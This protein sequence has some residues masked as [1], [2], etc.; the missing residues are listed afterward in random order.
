MIKPPTVN[1]P[2]RQLLTFLNH[3]LSI[4]NWINRELAQPPTVN[5]LNH[6]LFN[7]QRPSWLN[8][9]LA[10][11]SIVN[12]LLRSANCQLT[13]P[14]TGNLLIHQLSTNLAGDWQLAQPSTDNS[15]LVTNLPNHQLSIGS[16]APRPTGQRAHHQRPSW[17]NRHLANCQLSNGLTAICQLAQSPTV[18]CL[19]RRLAP[20]S[21]ANC[22]LAQSSTVNCQLSNGSTAIWQ[23]G[24]PPTVHW[25]CRQLSNA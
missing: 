7:D 21:I 3:Q 15:Q 23:L 1:V 13:L 14:V 19:S 9:H 12:C 5:V 4:G 17:L 16:L 8:R 18:K 20:C 2:N 11:C 22:Q 6:Q 25:L 24:E 10:P